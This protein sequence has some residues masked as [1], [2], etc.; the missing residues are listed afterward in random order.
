MFWKK[1]EGIGLSIVYESI[2]RKKSEDINQY[3]HFAGNHKLDTKGKFAKA[4][5]LYNIMSKK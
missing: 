5:K 4:R 1:E 3:I 2:S